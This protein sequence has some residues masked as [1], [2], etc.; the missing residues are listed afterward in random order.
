MDSPL[1]FPI[2]K[3]IKIKLGDFLNSYK[4]IVHL[5]PGTCNYLSINVNFYYD[6]SRWDVHDNISV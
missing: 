2:C 5:R 1:S 3:N 4:D 6:L